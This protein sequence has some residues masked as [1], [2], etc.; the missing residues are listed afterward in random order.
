MSFRTTIAVSIKVWKQ[1]WTRA[2]WS[3]DR[4]NN[5]W[6][7]ENFSSLHADWYPQILMLNPDYV[8]NWKPSSLV[9]IRSNRTQR[10][11]TRARVILSTILQFFDLFLRFIFCY[12]ARKLCC[13]IPITLKIVSHVEMF[14]CWVYM[15]LGN[16]DFMSRFLC[17]PLQIACSLETAWTRFS[18][19]DAN[20]E[21][22]FNFC[23][24]N[25]N[26]TFFSIS[27]L[28]SLFWMLLLIFRDSVLSVY[29]KFI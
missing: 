29:Y 23:I 28:F 19:Y 26:V 13:V 6:N 14:S 27:T 10:T 5:L 2:L 20:L 15:A 16:Y 25:S 22:L 8:C 1:E 12:V 18:R 9:W 3:I 21:M 7:R 11:W 17:Q 4:F 24:I